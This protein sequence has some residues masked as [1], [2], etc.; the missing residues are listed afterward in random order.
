MLMY[1]SHSLPY[2]VQIT[3]LYQATHLPYFE[4]LSKPSYCTH[5]RSISHLQLIINLS[6]LTDLS[7]TVAKWL[8]LI[9]VQFIQ[10][11][12]DS[13]IRKQVQLRIWTVI[14]VLNQSH[15][16]LLLVHLTFLKSTLISLVSC[17]LINLNPRPPS[18]VRS[19]CLF[20]T[21]KTD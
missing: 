10:S 18:L 13:Y 20:L 16:V 17:S 15:F 2:H 21:H 14:V 8:E 9:L 12:L 5:I 11:D 1:V 3:T 7:V 6:L 19:Y 4:A